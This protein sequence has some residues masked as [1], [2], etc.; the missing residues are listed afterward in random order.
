MISRAVRCK[1]T[2]S[3]FARCNM[4]SDSMIVRSACRCSAAARAAALC[5]GSSRRPPTSCLASGG[6]PSSASSHSE[7]VEVPSL[8]SPEPLPASSVP[9][10]SPESA[11]AHAGSP[12]FDAV[13]SC[14]TTEPDRINGNASDTTSAAS[15]VE[16]ARCLDALDR[17]L[18]A[19]IDA[20]M[21]PWTEKHSSSSLA[22]SRLAT[23]S[24]TP[25]AELSQEATA[26]RTLEEASTSSLP[27]DFLAFGQGG[28]PS[29][30]IRPVSF[31]TK[32][33]ASTKAQIAE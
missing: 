28:T 14:T 2:S 8:S 21:T 10:L 29:L 3:W 32:L 5:L 22:D 6:T 17:A 16:T 23:A 30:L 20:S 13:P 25:E 11:S 26:C 31:A 9:P 27:K 24:A 1:V 15:K 4:C 18:N 19:S 12:S 33:A 7:S